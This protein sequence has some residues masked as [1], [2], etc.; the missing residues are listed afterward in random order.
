MLFANR[1]YIFYNL[2]MLS[3][4]EHGAAPWDRKKIFLSFLILIVALFAILY[5]K[6]KPSPLRSGRTAQVKGE[7]APKPQQDQGT[8][9][10]TQRIQENFD[11]IKQ[12]VDNLNVV[13]VATSS[14]QIQKLIN[15]IKSL[16]NVPKNQAKGACE[17]ICQGL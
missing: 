3:N 17:R 16:E 5:F 7:S 1:K 15:D 12:N 10:T 13:D 4:K 9:S 2:A 8:S 6:D 11:R 14:P